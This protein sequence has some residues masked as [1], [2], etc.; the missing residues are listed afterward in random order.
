MRL[1]VYT[2][3]KLGVSRTR[4]SN[5]IKM[6]GVTVNGA[7]C[8]KTGAEIVPSNNIS[9]S[10][11]VKYASLGG[12]KLENAF[13]TLGVSPARKECLDVG[14]ANGGFT[15]C[16][17]V[18]GAKSVASVDLSLAFPPEIAADPRVTLYD[19]VNA[20]NLAEIFP[21]ESFDLI[22]VDLSFISL[23]PLFSLFFGL[24]RKGGSL[25]SLFKPQFEVGR[26]YLPKSG[27][28]R[29]KKVMEKA[30]RLTVESAVLAGFS[31]KGACDV[32][33]YFADKNKE[34]TVLFVK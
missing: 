15:Q 4:A 10:D 12:V 1:D 28:V 30:F 18:N 5:I 13:R 31:F 19:G 17:L 24:L 3:E 6:G 25:I 14:A 7:V 33:E 20:K 34:K 29:D 9:I 16:M 22:S 2:A 11:T 21:T 23:R 32:P 27:V 26:A 8:T